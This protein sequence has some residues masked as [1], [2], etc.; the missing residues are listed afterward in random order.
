M[1]SIAEKVWCFCRGPHAKFK[2]WLQT[3]KLS[4]HCSFSEDDEMDKIA[5]RDT[6]PLFKSAS[7]ITM[8]THTLMGTNLAHQ[9][10]LIA[11]NLGVDSQVIRRHSALS[12]A[13]LES[14]Q[15]P[16]RPGASHMAV[17]S[18]LRTYNVQSADLPTTGRSV[19]ENR[20]TVADPGTLAHEAHYQPQRS[21][22]SSP[23][24][25]RNKRRS[26]GHIYLQI[27]HDP[28]ANILYVT[29]LKA[30]LSKQLNEDGTDHVPVDPYV[31]CNIYPERVLENQ[32]RTRH[33]P[34]CSEPEFHQTMVYPNVSVNDLKEK[35]LEVCA[36]NYNPTG[37]DE[38]FGK[39]ILPLSG[40]PFVVWTDS[41]ILFPSFFSLSLWLSSSSAL[42][43]S[44]LYTNRLLPC[45]NRIKQRLPLIDGVFVGY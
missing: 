22:A 1:Q 12:S 27:C 40:N 34:M 31:V 26:S 29:V 30:K 5:V 25:L 9:S 2:K 21:V 17:M 36:W 20:L 7:S 37:N 43:I 41:F 4:F 18:H 15:L 13:E 16:H 3:C 8:T 19:N 24:P 6:R 11:D 10:T 45:K 28:K 23:R 39:V 44:Q 42:S 38:L 33:V 14:R 35:Q 32:R